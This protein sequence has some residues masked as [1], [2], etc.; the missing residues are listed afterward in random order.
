MFQMAS[1]VCPLCPTE[2]T[3]HLNFNLT[4]FMKHVKLFHSHQPDFSITCGL[5]GCL[6]TFKNYRTFQNHV[7]NFHAGFDTLAVDGGLPGAGSEGDDLE[8]ARSLDLV[9][10]TDDS[11]LSKHNVIEPRVG[12][13]FHWTRYVCSY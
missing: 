13:T 1:L 3:S 2:R 9:D 7:S 6:R 10:P 4:T 5:H 12:K 8:L 11:M